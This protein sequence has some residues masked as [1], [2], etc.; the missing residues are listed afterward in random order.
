MFSYP[1]CHRQLQVDVLL[2]QEQV[3]LLMLQT[4]PFVKESLDLMLFLLA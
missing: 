2:Q 4:V 3:F 1:F